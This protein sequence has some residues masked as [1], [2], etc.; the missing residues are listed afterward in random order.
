M[1]ACIDHTWLRREKCRSN[2]NWIPAFAGMTNSH[3]SGYVRESEKSWDRV[4][5]EVLSA[6]ATTKTGFRPSPE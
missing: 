5:G 4:H 2:E 6:A 3:D 1:K